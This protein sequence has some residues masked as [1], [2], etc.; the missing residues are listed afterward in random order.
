MPFH[1]PPHKHRCLHWKLK[2]LPVWL[3]GSLEFKS[4]LASS[5]ADPREV[6]WTWCLR[7]QPSISE[8]D[9]LKPWNTAAILLCPLQSLIIVKLNY[10]WNLEGFIHP[11]SSKTA[12][13]ER[14]EYLPHAVFIY[15]PKK[16]FGVQISFEPNF[17][18]VL[19]LVCKTW[20]CVSWPWD[21]LSNCCLVLNRRDNYTNLVW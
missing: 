19:C 8:L 15:S 16:F 4:F 13:K 5:S 2:C 11:V 17:Q 20:V 9:S 10:R 1:Q 21:C 6:I 14:S 7:T 18:C 3:S 12:T